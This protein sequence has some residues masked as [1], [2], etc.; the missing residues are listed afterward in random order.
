MSPGF[1]CPVSA[2]GFPLHGHV[3]YVG[4]PTT[5]AP[6][7]GTRALPVGGAGTPP[8][9][10]LG[11]R[12]RLCPL[13]VGAVPVEAGQEGRG[14]RGGSQRRPSGAGRRLQPLHRG[15]R[16]DR[17][18]PVGRRPPCH[19]RGDPAGRVGG[20]QPRADGVHPLAPGEVE[21]SA[22]RGGGGLAVRSGARGVQQPARPCA[23]ADGR[24]PGGGRH[25]R[26]RAQPGSGKCLHPRQHGMDPAGRGRPARR[27]G[28][29]P[30]GPAD[31]P[32][33]RVGA[34]GRDRGAEG[35]ALGVPPDPPLFLLDVGSWA[36]A[37]GGRW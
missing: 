7:G 15:S 6:A 19:S 32:G 33:K 29:L 4:A 36:A 34:A 35:A 18:E 3:L 14:V 37:R 27:A 11:A 9:V 17:P 8:G 1:G 30:R 24:P 28:T 2:V 22:G 25:A 10:S 13:P 12:R 5:R 20:A 16:T 21:G 31:R 23:S 26:R